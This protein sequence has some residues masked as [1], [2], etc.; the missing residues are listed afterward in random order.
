MNVEVKNFI[1]ENELVEPGKFFYPS[2]EC[3]P[4]SN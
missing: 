1:D 3:G 2:V 4:I